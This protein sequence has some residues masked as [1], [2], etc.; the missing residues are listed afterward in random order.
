MED[1]Y[2]VCEV[3]SMLVRRYATFYLLIF[4]LVAIFFFVSIPTDVHALSEDFV[5][6][7]VSFN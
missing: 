1:L 6:S 7:C 3:R 4:F 5:P 2:F